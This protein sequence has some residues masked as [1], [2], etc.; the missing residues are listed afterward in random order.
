M[1]RCLR[2]FPIILAALALAAGSPTTIL[3]KAG[4]QG[5]G[6]QLS[7]AAQQQISALLQ[8]KQ[9][10]TAAQKKINSQ[11]LYA[12]KARRGES[13]T[14]RGEVH[15]LSSAMDV[16]KI[17]EGGRVS[18]D[19]KS[20]SGRQLLETI[21]DLGGEV[22]YSSGKVGAI[23][24]LLPLDSLEK[25]A[26][27]PD[28]KSISPAAIAFTNRQAPSSGRTGLNGTSAPLG[29]S[30]V[31]PGFN[32]RAMNVRARL[33]EALASVGSLAN[34]QNPASP[35]SEGQ[36]IR[37]RAQ[38][39]AAEAQGPVTNAGS[40][41][42]QGNVA[43]NATAARNFFGVS[44]TGVRIGVLSDGVNF[45]AQL[46][47]SGNLPA[48]LTV[49]PGQSGPP[50]AEGTAML[51]IVHDLAPGAKLFFATAFNSIESFADN[52]RALRAA[53]CDIIVD[54]VI[55]TNESPFHDDV[56]STAVN[57]VVADGALYFS[58]A[59]N[60]GNFN[61]G[62]SGT[63]E[64]DFKNS[65]VTLPLLPGGTLHN[66][67]SGVISNFVE[68]GGLITTLHWSDPLGASDN[69]YDFFIMDNTLTTVLAASTEVQDGDDD[70][71]EITFGAPAGSRILVFKA[72][73][74]QRRALHLNN[75]RGQ[76]GV[77]TPGTIRGHAGAAGAFAV[78]AINVAVAGGGSFTGGPTNPVELFSA[79]GFR[80]VF[81]KS[82]GTPYTPGNLLFSSNGGEARKKPDLTAADGVAT[83]VP[84]FTTF[85]GTS[86]AAPHAAA[87]AGLLKSARP[88][89]APDRIRRGLTRTALDIEAA[90]VDRDSGA[91]I[92]DAF[93]ALQFIDADP[94]PFL[95]VGTVM[96][97]A[98]GGDGDNFVEPG[99]GGM[100]TVA[101]A[102]VGGA[103][104]LGVSA[105]LTTS[106]PG[107]TI[108]SATS[109]Y[110]DIG[111]NGQSANNVTPF[112]FTL[113]N[114]APCGV[115][116]DFTLTVN[117]ANSNEGPQTLAF[118]V[119]TD[120]ANPTVISYTGPP[121]PIPSNT[122]GT[123]NIPIVVSGLSAPI[124]D[125][126]FS[127]DGSS[128]TNAPF[129]TTV[130]LDHTFVG[131]LI[132]TLTS[133]QGTTVTLMNQPGGFF[134]GG[135]N[136]CNTVLDDSA[137]NFIQAITP[138]GAPYT[139]AFK[140]A[141]PL[142]AFNGQDGNG[143]W[144]LTVTD[145]FPADGGNVRAFSLTFSSSACGDTTPPTS[146]I[147]S[148]PD[149]ATVLIGALVPIL[150]FASDPGGGSVVRVEVSVDGGATFSAATGTGVWSFFNWTP[151]LPGPVTI[152]SRAVDNAG[153][154]QNPP[155]EIHVT[156][157]GPPTSTITSPTEGATLPIG[158]P[159]AITGTA[160]DPGGSVAQ[161]EVSVDGG[162]SYSPA[163][164]TNA[165]SFNWTPS[166][167]GSVT[168]KSRAVDNIGIM[169]NPPAE[170]HVTVVAQPTTIRVPSDQPTIQSAINVATFGDTVLV[171]PGTY[172]E[173]INF[174]GKAITVTS[175]SGPQVT[176][177][178]GGNANPVVTFTSGEGRDS[179]INGFTLQNGIAFEGGGARV[180]GSSPTITN[181]VI[182]NNNACA[183]GGIGI[184]FGSPLIQLNTI[185]GNG[186]NIC[187]GGFG[188]GI[189]IGGASSVEILDNVIS[190]NVNSDG[191][192]ISMFAAGTPII[193]RN[194]IK[195]NN[196]GGQGGG[197]WMVNFSDA[198]IVQ[199]I[200][201][202]NQATVGGGLYWLVPGGARGPRL[203]NNTIADNN[204]F[205]IGSG[206]FADGFDVQ[207][208]LTNNIIV[209]KPG[210]TGLHCGDLND[211]NP[212]IIRFNN[213]FSS[214][215]MA[216]GGICANRTGTDGNISA[217]PLF[218]NPTQGDY[219]LQ[220]GSPSIDSGDNLTPD[221]PDTDVDG[222]PRILDGDGNGTAIVDMG[223]DEFLALTSFD[224]NL[225]DESNGNMLKI[226]STNGQYLFYSMRG[227]HPWRRRKPDRERQ[228][229]YFPGPRR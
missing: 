159:V 195:G 25:L 114:T 56:V 38:Q 99:E 156:V 37:L 229:G 115:A 100:L 72:D 77:T 112:A 169:Q 89:L 131:D 19:I 151:S 171:A 124:G 108:T 134:N 214:G 12:M 59:G 160:S 58:S 217:D 139:G 86:A 186:N 11:L 184:G 155:T 88:R 23:R 118:K 5:E 150:G 224:I 26:G 10:R 183:G 50:G 212:P 36:M 120:E 116:I 73:V 157:S 63:W 132:V 67:G 188:G 60:E 207:T 69:D 14:A 192:G 127:F 204:A 181:N 145:V 225:Q 104:A 196:V 81:Y 121:A 51:E 191:G 187:S 57:E 65:G 205:S 16:A 130:G 126:N 136:F 113:A 101:L 152:K 176:I 227:N 226:N 172:F 144:T 96:M 168:I 48:D 185:T 123:I 119:Q 180:Q 138:A 31:R 3:R 148:P 133:P 161:V 18:V 87:I 22:I 167:P 125:L 33:T 122:V 163:T 158:I 198:L 220:Q 9:S 29:M 102:N 173:N 137:T 94:A 109:N 49:L 46:I 98:V 203:V 82:D 66:F 211:Q 143:A 209:A 85:F 76:L 6:A 107:V 197:I 17:D 52:I 1:R 43:H 117:V 128:C 45:L 8:E 103:T 200:I 179:V 193:K 75:F 42:S 80:R 201:A 111:S 4:A 194:I 140:P 34:A 74:A 110:P 210:Q 83:S 222:D 79:D 91:G 190:D 178:D 92:V 177:I 78:A 105:T 208:E 35:L 61:D 142:A 146:T 68:T 106:T 162:A 175:E 84:G 7:A 20:A 147:V 170:I 2:F 70:P 32:Q 95:E 182:R 90:G 15:T 216:Y 21:K 129:A 189:S 39:P 93:A 215:G 54:D 165:W 166:S 202:G 64:G 218:T 41:N 13:L 153:N 219:H 30:G 53:G 149:G 135:R 199:N 62:T 154:V 28:V 141:S 223:V 55:Y 71:F 47:A 27:H 97:T 221:L 164:G 24:A 228:S 213:I 44:G 206:I 174:A 40:V